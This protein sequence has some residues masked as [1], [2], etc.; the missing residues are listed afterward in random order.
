MK[1]LR[2][3]AE[4]KDLYTNNLPLFLDEYTLKIKEKLPGR[5]E[6]SA[7]QTRLGKAD[8]PVLTIA[9]S[10]LIGGYL[11]MAHDCMMRGFIHAAEQAGREVCGV[12][13]LDYLTTTEEQDGLVD[14]A[15]LPRL[16]VRT[17]IGSQLLHNPVVQKMRGGLGFEEIL[18]EKVLELVEKVDKETVIVV[19]HYGVAKTL[20]EAGYSVLVAVTDPSAELTH[21]GYYD[22]LTEENKD[23]VCYGTMDQLTKEWLIENGGVKQENIREVGSFVSPKLVKAGK[24]KVENRLK[25]WEECMNGEKKFHVGIFTGGLGTNFWEMRD[26]VLS[27]VPLV[28]EEKLKI[29]VFFNMNTD[30]RDHLKDILNK[31][32]YTNKSIEVYASRDKDEL[33]KKSIEILQAADL[34]FTKPS[35]DKAFETLAAGCIPMFLFPLHPH[36]VRIR[37]YVYQTGVGIEAEEYHYLH[38]VKKVLFNQEVYAENIYLTHHPEKDQVKPISHQGEEL[39]LEFYQQICK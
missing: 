2:L 22:F 31:N 7:V 11:T 33:N 16:V 37:E 26:V 3:L 4:A 28:E 27:L 9:G 8:I 5:E 1:K 25:H 35:G 39:L 24:S 12:D 23:K 19:F 20:I 30:L 38:Q 34:V 15:K 13:V 18:K 21:A 32:D 36:E 14:M 6:L 17:E 29:S 10:P